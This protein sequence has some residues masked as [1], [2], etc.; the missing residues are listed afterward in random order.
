MFNP[1]MYDMNQIGKEFVEFFKWIFQDSYH[2]Q[3]LNCAHLIPDFIS[4]VD[5]E[6]LLRLPNSKE[7]RKTLFSMGI[8]KA[9]GP[10]GYCGGSY[11]NVELSWVEGKNVVQG[12]RATLIKFVGLAMPTYAMETTK[13]SSHL[14][15]KIDGMG[16]PVLWNNLWNS[17]IFERH[18]ILWWSILSEALL[19]RS[20]LNKDF[21][22]EDTHGPICGMED[23]S[24][25]HLFL[26]C[27]LAYH[28]WCTSPWRIF[29]MSD[30]GI[31]VCDWI[32]FIWNLQHKG[33]NPDEVFLY[34]S[35]VVDTIWRVWNDKI[36]NLPLS[37]LL[38]RAAL[39]LGVRLL[40]IGSN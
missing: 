21:L 19:T 8:N 23:E 15:T 26:H 18:K 7:I 9:P 14:A 30:T 22:I 34:A 29:S 2:G 28:L 10:D 32:K 20:T 12:S 37:I 39:L 5:Q 25:G 35:V 1:K 13:L 16:A 11:G 36:T 3:R 17:K 38:L 4:Q 31:R 24:T 27:N 6:E 40:K 33:V